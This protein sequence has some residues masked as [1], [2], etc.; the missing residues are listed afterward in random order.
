M[1]SNAF[2]HDVP[3]GS[4]ETHKGSFLHHAYHS[5]GDR[6]PA[7]EHAKGDTVHSEVDLLK[8]RDWSPVQVPPMQLSEAF[9]INAN[10]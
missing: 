9:I 7:L 4:S 5:V 6:K 2:A 3:V 10:G 1:L 8:S